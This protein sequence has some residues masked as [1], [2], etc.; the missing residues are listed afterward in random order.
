MAKS[1]LERRCRV[2]P[3]FI[4]GID[5]SMQARE[6]QRFVA[7]TNLDPLRGRHRVHIVEVEVLIFFDLAKLLR[8]GKAGE[9][10]FAGN[11]RERDGALDEACDALA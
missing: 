9:G 6:E 1:G 11:L 5:V 3:G 8:F 4:G 2:R 7:S 10:V